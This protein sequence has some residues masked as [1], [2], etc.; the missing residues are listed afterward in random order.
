MRQMQFGTDLAFSGAKDTLIKAKLIHWNR[1][2]E[3]VLKK[4][5]YGL[6]VG[7]GPETSTRDIWYGYYIHLFAKLRCTEKTAGTRVSCRR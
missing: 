5:E 3:F 2:R 1:P 6:K 4:F 7:I